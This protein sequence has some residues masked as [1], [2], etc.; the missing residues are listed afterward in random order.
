MLGGQRSV[1]LQTG[2]NVGPDLLTFTWPNQSCTGTLDLPVPHAVGD[3]RAGRGFPSRPAAGSGRLLYLEIASS[4]KVC[5]ILF[6]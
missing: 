2:D 6:I 3:L 5:E 1:T 4:F